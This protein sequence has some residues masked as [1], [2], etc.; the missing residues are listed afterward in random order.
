MA[1]AGGEPRTMSEDLPDC[2]ELPALTYGSAEREQFR[3]FPDR[4]HGDD[5]VLLAARHVRHRHVR[6][7]RRNLHLRHDRA[8][9]FVI[10]AEPRHRLAVDGVERA[11]LAGQQQRLGHHDARSSWTPRARN[12]DPLEHLVV[13]DVLGRAADRRHPHVIARVH[14]DR[15]DAAVWRLEERQAERVQRWCGLAGSAGTSTVRS[16]RPPPAGGP[17]APSAPPSPRPRR[18]RHRRRHRCNSCSSA[19][20][21]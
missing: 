12:R 5:D 18:G 13:L 10:G 8:G 16:R 1:S 6:D 9:R 4:R 21:R 2:T 3:R 20:D 14:V 19:P 7:V 17:P 11:A 15:R